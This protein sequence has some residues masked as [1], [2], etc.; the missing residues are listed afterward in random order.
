[1]TD[2]SSPKT[3]PLPSYAQLY[4]YAA[5]PFCWKVR[6]LL[7]YLHVPH[8][9]IEV[10]PITKK[11]IAFSKE[12]KKVPIFI[13][14]NGVKVTDSN[15]I[16]RHID[17]KYGEQSLFAKEHDSSQAA[18]LERERALFELSEQIVFA[19][20]PVIYKTLS[21]SWN[22]FSYITEVSHFS[23]WEKWY[24]R[25]F[26]SFVMYFVAK[27]KAKARG[28]TQPQEHLQKLLEELEQ[29]LCKH[30]MEKV[31]AGDLAAWGILRSSAALPCFALVEERSDLYLLYHS[32]EKQL[33]L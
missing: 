21:S 23:W 27:K 5:C 28:I 29:F 25:L 33:E 7:A 22:A 3:S 17:Q 9:V 30:P 13:D 10:H 20:P 2:S 15:A 8:K 1:M 14:Q 31:T 4:Q 6:A 19:L 24:V 16:M 12:Y 18:L 11:E 32:L 26:G